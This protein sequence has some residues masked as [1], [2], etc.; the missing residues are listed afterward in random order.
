MAGKLH[1]V[2]P[3]IAPDRRLPRQVLVDD[4]GREGLE[5]EIVAVA[6]GSQRIE[7]RREIDAAGAEEATMAFADMDITDLVGGMADG[8]PDIGLLDVHV[9]GVKVQEDVAGA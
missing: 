1:V 6:N 5:A 9:E 8:Q 3:Q 2:G 7:D 4:L